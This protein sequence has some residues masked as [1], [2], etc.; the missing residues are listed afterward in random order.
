VAVFLMEAAGAVSHS[1]GWLSLFRTVGSS[2]IDRP[3]GL[4]SE[5][6][7]FGTFAAL[8]GF[9]LILI[10]P[11]GRAPLR[12]IVS[13]S[14]FAMAIL[15]RAKTFVPVVLADCIALIWREGRRIFR[16]KYLLGI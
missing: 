13:G 16:L 2:T 9:P 10:R 14:L 6:A 4:M 3:S 12:W 5:P 8:Y 11:I 1:D 7:Y 15:I